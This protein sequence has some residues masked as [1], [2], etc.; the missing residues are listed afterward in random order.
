M[1]FHNHITDTI[2]DV[3][4][5]KFTGTIDALWPEIKDLQIDVYDDINP[6]PRFLLKDYFI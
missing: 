6:D 5:Q 1:K 3:F 4:E 2:F